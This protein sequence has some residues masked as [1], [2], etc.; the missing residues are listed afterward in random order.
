MPSDDAEMRTGGHMTNNPRRRNGHRRNLVIRRLRSEGRPCWICVL[1]GKPGT[2]DYSLR[3]PHPYSFVVDELVPVSKYWLGGYQSAEQAA[4]DYRNLAAA[5]KCCNEWRGNKTVDEV[6][7]LI[8]AT[9]SGDA[10]SKDVPRIIGDVTPSRDW[11]SFKAA[12]GG[13]R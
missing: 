11:R 12:K 7:R 10:S 9:R 2:I 8:A 4:L 13:A 3:F 1:A 5:H 6:K